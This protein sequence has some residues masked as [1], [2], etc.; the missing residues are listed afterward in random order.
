MK[1]LIE[2]AAF[3][4]VA[5]AAH[6]GGF[7]LLTQGGEGAGGDGGAGQITLEGGGPG[8][9]AL[10]AAWEAP[11]EL[12]PPPELQPE[13]M[14]G[15]ADMAGEL[16]PLPGPDAPAFAPLQGMTPPEA[17]AEPLPD[18]LPDTAPPA[19]PVAWA[20]PPEPAPDLPDPSSAHDALPPLSTAPTPALSSLLAPM[21]EA[22]APDTA[23]PDTA[24]PD[25]TPPPPPLASAEPPGRSPHPPAR[26]EP[27]PEPRAEPGTGPRTPAAPAAAPAPA[28]R[29]AGSGAQ[30]QA[31]L[32]AGTRQTSRAGVDT[33]GLVAQWGGAVR[34]A[35][36]R[37]QRRPAHIHGTGTVVLRLEVHADGRLL[38]VAVQ[39]GSGHAALDQAALDAARRARIPAAPEGLSGTF[40]F[41]LPVRFRG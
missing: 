29:A 4:A 20:P 18:T 10:V 39:Q 19:P 14:T 37:V 41:N 40:Q 28:Q 30:G 24:L 6:I 36:Q 1:T 21:P 38:R 26:P 15:P 31:G 23:P 22:P 11:P 3:L 32:A 2:G 12:V 25:T 5:L 34:A 16:P 8:H 13:A 7:A 33:G 35:I 17:P 9:A 27:R